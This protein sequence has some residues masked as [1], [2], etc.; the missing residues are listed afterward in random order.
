M[1]R[2][3]G[4][5]ARRRRSIECYVMYWGRADLDRKCNARIARLR[6][7]PATKAQAGKP[8]FPESR[9]AAKTLQRQRG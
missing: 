2:N 5:P 9:S 4:L 3:P 7:P 8:D 6:R 1:P